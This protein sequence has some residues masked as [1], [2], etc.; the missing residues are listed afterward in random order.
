VFAANIL[1][2]RKP[3]IPTGVAW[4]A[5]LV[6]L[7]VNFLFPVQTLLG[8]S[9]PLRVLG[10][11]ALIGTPVFCAGIS[12]SSLFKR[13]TDVGLPFG[14]NMVGAMTGGSIEYLSMLMGMR[15]IWLI[16]VIVYVLAFL[17]HRYNVR[18]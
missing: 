2:E 3:N 4:A 16:L 8:F 9:F 5:L 11:A 10:A 6:A 17:C 12:F 1:M 15:N 13:E 14:M 7:A 18:S